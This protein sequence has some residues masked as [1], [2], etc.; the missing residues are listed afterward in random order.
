MTPLSSSPYGRWRARKFEVTD[1]DALRPQPL[2]H[3]EPLRLTLRVD[4]P[5][6][7]MDLARISEPEAEERARV[8]A[9]LRERFPRLKEPLRSPVP[10]PVVRPQRIFLSWE[11]TKIRT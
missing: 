6:D 7:G 10:P 4:R 11:A 8:S 9:A 1:G 3:E 2:S 5:L